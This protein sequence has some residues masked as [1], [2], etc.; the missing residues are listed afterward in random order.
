M[1]FGDPIKDATYLG[2]EGKVTLKFQSYGRGE[3]C[4][5]EET[6]KPFAA[7]NYGFPE[8][9]RELIG[10][11]QVGWF[12]ASGG[13]WLST[14]FHFANL[15]SSSNS[16]VID[17]AQGTITTHQNDQIVTVGIVCDRLADPDSAP[18]VCSIDGGSA[19]AT[20]AVVRNLVV[21][22][23][24]QEDDDT[25]FATLRGFRIISATGRYILP[26]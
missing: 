23:L 3:I 10:R 25:P 4:L 19:E 22:N 16:N 7:F 24:F 20:L 8:S 9:A 14:E 12:D 17:R 21:G 6:C 11:W 2:S 26:N 1:A 5:P 15:L 18:Y 13:E